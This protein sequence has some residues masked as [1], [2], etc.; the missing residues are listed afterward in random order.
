MQ[1]NE[2]RD[3][4]RAWLV[5]AGCLGPAE[6][7]R[8]RALQALA[9]AVPLVVAPR[10]FSS[11]IDLPK[12][13]ALDLFLLA[14]WAALAG[15]WISRGKIFARR[16]G[17]DAPVAFMLVS[18]LLSSLLAVNPWLGADQSVLLL[19]YAFLAWVIINGLGVALVPRLL[20]AVMAA[21]G[22]VALYG[23]LQYGGIDFM[24]WSSSWGSRCFG[25]I[26]NPIFFAE[27]IAPIFVLALVHLAAEENEERKDLLGLL[28]LALFLAL[29]FAQTRSSW[30]GSLAG[31]IV[32]LAC[33]RS[34][35]PGGKNLLT[36]NRAWLVS[37]LVFAV[38]VTLT[39]SSARFFGKA[40]LPLRDRLHDMVNMKGWTVRHRLVLWRAGAMMLR[41]APLAGVGPAHYRTYFS[42]KQA[43]FRPSLAAKGFVF[44]PKEGK[45]HN[46]YVQVAAETGL[47]GLG[48][49][50]WMLAAVWRAGILA[51][52]RAPSPG[53]GAS[54]SG[55]LGG[56]TALAVDA[57]FNFPFDIIPAAT[58][59]WIYAGCL[60]LMAGGTPREIPFPAV[61]VPGPVR[62]L[63]W[64]VSSAAAAL[65]LAW[66]AWPRMAADRASAEG[67]YYLDSGMWE[68][69]QGS[70]E[71]AQKWAPHDSMVQYKLGTAR[72]K[73]STY[74]W[75]GRAWDRALK[76][77]RAAESMG[78]RDELLY[79]RMALLYE[80][81]GDMVRAAR[82]GRESVRIFPE[83][84]DNLSNLAYWLLVRND[85]ISEALGY[86]EKAVAMV[87]NHPMYLWTRG[88]VLEKAGRRKQALASMELAMKYLDLFPDGRIY[89]Q[90][91]LLKDIGRVRGR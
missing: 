46:D 10:I 20:S 86:A 15:D 40:A 8:L 35:S 70:F 22:A 82:A 81:K 78:M 6:G 30:L 45:S 44:P 4:L 67:N 26:G 28:V 56:C 42:V 37:A 1:A 80:K 55:M 49:F 13:L 11:A 43:V 66:S 27:F 77:Y 36:R 16:T 68:M 60:A 61:L 32:A 54:A 83:N 17:L 71:K 5:P 38:A 29:L 63:A 2:I 89:Y 21:G 62:R 18:A 69:A 79:G 58:V 51:V 87:P 85:S 75:T 23:I 24:P 72:E 52:A 84:A 91:D 9:V 47:L 14:A 57:F 65:L 25:T 41:D 12:R 73:G 88:L 59:F 3:R 31:C 33:I 39:I 76:S 48:M 50:L 7:A 34:R 53:A 64:L 19:A 74:D 90:A